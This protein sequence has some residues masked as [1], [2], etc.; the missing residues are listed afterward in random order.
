MP[1]LVGAPVDIS[2]AASPNVTMFT[3]AAIRTL[4]C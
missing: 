4:G 2:L 3:K 1:G